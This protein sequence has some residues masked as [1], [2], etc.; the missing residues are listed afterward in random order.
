MER[1]SMSRLLDVVARRLA[2]ETTLSRRD[3][4]TARRAASSSDQPAHAPPLTQPANDPSAHASARP[5]PTAADLRNINAALKRALPARSEVLALVDALK[6]PAQ[7]GHISHAAIVR[8]GHV[9]SGLRAAQR[10]IAAIGRHSSVRADAL[11]AIADTDR[12]FANLVAI[13]QTND[14]RLVARLRSQSTTLQRRADAAARR[15]GRVLS[16]SSS[17]AGAP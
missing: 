6:H 15:A 5:A 11:T 17:K 14:Q 3:L 7:N 4:I 16:H 10:R 8:I 2:A 12:I 1:W 13:G 9:R